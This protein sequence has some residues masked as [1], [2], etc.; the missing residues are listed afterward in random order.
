MKIQVI[1][2][3]NHLDFSISAYFIDNHYGWGYSNIYEEITKFAM[4]GLLKKG[5]LFYMQ[6]IFTVV[7][8]KD[9]KG[10][11]NIRFPD[12][13]ECRAKGMN[14]LDAVKKSQ[15]VLSLCLF[16]MEQ[17]GLMIPE[18]RLPDEITTEEGEIASIIMVDTSPYHSRFGEDT[19]EYTLEI[20]AWLAEVVNT[21][22]LDLSHLLQGAVRQRIG[23]PAAKVM[24]KP[25][26]KQADANSVKTPEPESDDTPQPIPVLVPVEKFAV[27]HALKEGGR[28]VLKSFDPPKASEPQP[29]EAVTPELEVPGKPATE[30]SEASALEISQVLEPEP[31]QAEEL[32]PSQAEFEQPKDAAPNPLASNPDLLYMF[33]PEGFKWEERSAAKSRSKAKSKPKSKSKFGRHAKLSNVI[34]WVL[35]VLAIIVVVAAILL[36]FTDLLDN[37]PFISNVLSVSELGDFVAWQQAFENTF[38]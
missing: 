7:F 11:I 17:Q 34:M 27:N 18:P 26:P 16:D 15:S 5:V 31:L 36:V 14:M 6:Y 24:P 1:T 2:E 4:V 23:M 9:L 19:K 28:V 38:V 12:L 30:S 25:K 37:V 3:S 33:E 13:P 35:T 10:L 32:E 29:V 22:K 20:P 8:K 21:S